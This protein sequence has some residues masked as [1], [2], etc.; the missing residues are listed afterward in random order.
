MLARPRQAASIAD[1]PGNRPHN[2]WPQRLG[3]VE[4]DEDGVWRATDLARNS[5]TRSCQQL[6]DLDLPPQSFMH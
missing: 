3:L 5:I 1:G 6:I 4:V 2:G